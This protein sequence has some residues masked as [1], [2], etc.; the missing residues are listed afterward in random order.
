M[1]ARLD[2]EIAYAAGLWTTPYRRGLLYLL[3]Q[4]LRVSD[5]ALLAAQ[6]DVAYLF[7]FHRNGFLRERALNQLHGPIES[8]F[9]VTVLAYRLNDWVPQVRAAAAR[10]ADRVLPSTSPEIIAEAAMFLL[11]RRF[12]WGRWKKEAESLDQA[13]SRRDV[14]DAIA[15]VLLHAR[16]GPMGAILRHAT[17]WAAI[18]RH[19]EEL[20]T[21]AFLP[22]VRAI[23][24][25]VQIDGV[26]RWPVGWTK[27]WTNKIYGE[28][29][30]VRAYDE[31]PVTGCRALETC[32]KQGA[33]DRSAAVRK[34]AATALVKVRATLSNRDLIVGLLEHDSSAAVRQRV[35]FVKRSIPPTVP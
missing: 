10:C 14:V 18:D 11:G 12:A 29:R 13:L 32:V 19:L 24:L 9:Y 28:Y 4:R 6:P 30:P 26:A 7:I 1:I 2:T 25:Q 21:G 16:S 23:A 34:I 31:R 5:S 17:R 8:A 3:L 20:S 15:D 35:E 27:Q 33:R 22:S